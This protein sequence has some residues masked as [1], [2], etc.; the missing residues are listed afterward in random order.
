MT[1]SHDARLGLLSRLRRPEY[2]GENRCIPCTVV[3]VALALAGAGTLAA[4]GRPGL[5]AGGLAGALGVIWLR[6]YLVPGT[7][8]LTKRYL[9]ERVLRLFG[10]GRAA[11][12][13]ADID[14]ESYL[15]SADVLVETPD[16][17]DLAFAPWFASAWSDA[18]DGIRLDA[19]VADADDADAPITE[20]ADAPTTHDADDAG[21]AADVAALAALTGIDADSLSLDW[22][23]ETA[24][25]FADGERIG[26]WESRAAFL[27]DVAAD[28]VLTD[29]VDD[30]T[31]LS[32]P[33]RSGVLGALR[34]FVEDCPACEGSV[35][36]EERV[37]ESCCS[38]YDVV[39]GRCTACN[40]RLF[41][42]DLPPSLA[43][44]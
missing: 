23:G 20:A 43:T 4:F 36:L 17:A 33:A 32:L 10:K 21:T 35:I 11:A 42:L 38:S 5:G 27:A 1:T 34:L 2:T 7:P 18:L 26:H 14:A 31:T 13:P 25:A 16:E 24:F 6:G 39:A 9:P 15:L 40:A 28:R 44:E 29:R 8:H 41:E 22:R 19:S 30:W 37:V 12:P 3:N